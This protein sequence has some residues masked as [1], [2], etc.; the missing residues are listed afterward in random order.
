MQ[1]QQ[2]VGTTLTLIYRQIFHYDQ[3]W[4]TEIWSI[5]DVQALRGPTISI[6]QCLILKNHHEF[7]DQEVG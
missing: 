2:V 6:Q 3:V 5:L 4:G 1:K 7:I